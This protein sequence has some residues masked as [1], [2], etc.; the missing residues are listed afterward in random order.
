MKETLDLFRLGATT[1]SIPAQ[2]TGKNKILAQMFN[3][4]VAIDKPRAMIT[5]KYWAEFLQLTSSRDRRVKF[6]SLDEYIPYRVWDVGQMW[7][8]LVPHIYRVRLANPPR[9]M[10]GFVTFGMSL[11]IPESDVPVAISAT[12]TAFGAIALTNDLFSWERE[13]DAAKRDGMPHV[14]NA[15]WVIMGQHSVSE[16]EAKKICHN[17]IVELV[18]EFKATVEQ[19]R[20]DDS[21]CED[22][23]TFVEVIQ[24]NV[25]GNLAWS[26]SCSR[27]NPESKLNSC[28]EWM[29]QKVM[30]KTPQVLAGV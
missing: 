15:V 10:F 26:L 2:T 8:S 12:S 13:R 5:A 11:T 20:R 9:L 17:K 16:S 29:R 18:E 30:Q 14:V 22:L 19:F 25:S 6:D 3:E 21:V 1:G 27:Y 24:F 23:R 4:M 7:V 28:Q